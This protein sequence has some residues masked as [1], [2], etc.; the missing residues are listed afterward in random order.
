ML[1]VERLERMGYRIAIY[2]SETQRAGIYAMR[3]TL[4]LLKRE[5]T[6]EAMDPATFKGGTNVGL[7]TG[8]TERRYLAVDD[9]KP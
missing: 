9:E 8:K 6:T 2:P 7:M 4:A 5:G 1:P 3:Q